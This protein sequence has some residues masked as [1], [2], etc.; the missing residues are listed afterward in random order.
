MELVIIIPAYGRDD[1]LRRALTSLTAQSITDFV[2]LV[3]DDC[4]PVPLSSVV[5]E[6]NDKLNIFYMRLEENGGPGLARQSGLDWAYQEGYKYVMFMDSDDI[7]L[8]QAAA[9][10]LYEIKTTKCDLISSAIWKEGE[11]PG[12]PGEIIS[13]SNETWMHGKIFDIQFLYDNDLRFPMMRL[14][15]DMTFNL[16]AMELSDKVGQLNEVTYIFKHQIGSI[17]RG[18]NFKMS[19]VSS[20]FII[21]MYHTTKFLKSK[22]KITFQI[23]V[24]IIALYKHYQIAKAF[25]Y[26]TKEINDY[27]YYMLTLPEVDAALNDAALMEKLIVA[28][29]PCF[30]YDGKVLWFKQSYSDWVEEMLAYGNSNN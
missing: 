26:I 8:P 2:T 17:T 7:L 13:S 10:L 12:L 24:N 4:S 11:E 15:E 23:L 16:N 9:R 6:F 29:P 28:I 27:V 19:M 20:D 3:V 30:F 14:N 18:E 21:G 1:C 25:N 5:S 22:N